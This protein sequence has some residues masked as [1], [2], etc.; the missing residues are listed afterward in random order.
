MES[1]T[2]NPYRARYYDPPDEL[3]G[4]VFD[5]SSEVFGPIMRAI[6]AG[7]FAGAA[8]RLTE[9]EEGDDDDRSWTPPP[10]SVRSAGEEPSRSYSTFYNQVT[11]HYEATY[12]DDLLLGGFTL[13]RVVDGFRDEF[14]SY[15]LGDEYDHRRFTDAELAEIIGAGIFAAIAKASQITKREEA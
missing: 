1:Y 6:Q 3:A 10:S 4:T 14:G 13:D 15:E 5:P 8:H 2:V 11:D 7:D 9:L 12:K